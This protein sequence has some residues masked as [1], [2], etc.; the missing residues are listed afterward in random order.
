MYIG[1]NEQFTTVKHAKYNDKK[2]FKKDLSCL[3]VELRRLGLSNRIAN[4]LDSDDYEFG[5][6]FQS[7]SKCNDNLK[8]RLNNNVD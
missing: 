3:S 8:F 5:R 7:D 1:Y 6:Q 2:G 4:G